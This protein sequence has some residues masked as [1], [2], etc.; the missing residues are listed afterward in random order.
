MPPNEK[1]IIY[2]RGGGHVVSKL[3]FY[4]DYPSSNTA[5]L[6]FFLYNFC[7]TSEERQKEAGVV[8]TIIN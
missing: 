3:V 4:S 1:T 5:G 2:G 6:Y 8:T 7:L